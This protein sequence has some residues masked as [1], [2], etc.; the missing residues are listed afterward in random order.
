MSIDPALLLVFIPTFFVVSATPGMCMT[1]ALSLGMSIGPRRTLWMMTGGLIGVAIVAV[2]AAVG[3]AAIMLNH[4]TVFAGFKVLGGIYLGWL[5]V[6]LW[7]SRGQ[8]AIQPDR[9]DNAG[10][11]GVQLLMQGLITA[12]ANPKGWAFVVAL[13]PPFLDNTRALAPQLIVLV[14]LMLVIEFICLQLYAH[15]GHWLSRWLGQRG[16]VRLINRL[17]GALMI[18]VGVWLLLG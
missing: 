9:S 4:P 8:L 18:G 17:A 15:G 13:L 5:G 14:T 2:A 3:V 6:Q 11:S 7:R 10:G 1:L 16:N 12:V